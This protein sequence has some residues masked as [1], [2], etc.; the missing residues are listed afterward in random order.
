MLGLCL[1]RRLRARIHFEK[2]VCLVSGPAWSF[3]LAEASSL[4]K[5]LPDERS[6]R[7][8]SASPDYGHLGCRNQRFPPSGKPPLSPARTSTSY[9]DVT[10]SDAEVTSLTSR[11][12]MKSGWLT[13]R[14]ALLSSWRSVFS[15]MVEGLGGARCDDALSEA[16]PGTA[17]SR[18][19]A[20]CRRNQASRPWLSSSTS[21]RSLTAHPA[22]TRRSLIRMTGLRR[23]YRSGV[24]F[25]RPS[26]AVWNERRVI[27]LGELQVPVTPSTSLRSYSGEATRERAPFHAWRLRCLGL[28]RRQSGGLLRQR[29][30]G[31]HAGCTLL[32]ARVAGLR[33]TWFG[34]D[35][36]TR[37]PDH[38][39]R[40]VGRRSTWTH[41]IELSSFEHVMC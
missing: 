19:A 1:V 17:S 18:R 28:G 6:P 7:T 35:A 15:S 3:Q 25:G 21:S 2:P 11:T 26:L 37:C 39:D 41:A 32:D 31:S 4:W 5:F 20:L 16:G 38:Q 29:L 10:L 30:W 23:V 12:S 13:R 27:G 24:D 9:Y 36:G 40:S 34:R 22:T 8:C 33:A 14:G